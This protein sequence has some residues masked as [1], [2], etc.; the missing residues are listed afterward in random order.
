MAFKIPRSAICTTTLSFSSSGF[1]T[2]FP[3]PVGNHAALFF[4]LVG[5][6]VSKLSVC[7]IFIV[8]EIVREE[9][10]SVAG[11]RRLRLAAPRIPAG[12]LGR[13]HWRLACLQRRDTG[14]PQSIDSSSNTRCLGT[15]L[16]TSSLPTNLSPMKNFQ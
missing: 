15:V 8:A 12:P 4:A 2:H 11:M 16:Y 13:N 5:F 9:H 6:C 1:S 3:Y 14:N 10:P 7:P